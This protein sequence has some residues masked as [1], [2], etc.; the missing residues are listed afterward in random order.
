LQPALVAGV[1]TTMNNNKNTQQAILGTLNRTEF[2]QV[3][4]AE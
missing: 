4:T 3:G 2:L 1:A